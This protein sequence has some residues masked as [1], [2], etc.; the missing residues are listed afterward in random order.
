MISDNEKY[1]HFINH[2][3][4]AVLTT[5]RQSGNPVSSV[6][7]YAIDGNQLVI[8][9]PGMTFKRKTLEHD[10]RVNLTIISNEE[11]F[12]FVAIEGEATI[13]TNDI[14]A[15][16]KSVFANISGSGYEEPENLAEWLKIQKRVI[17][18]IDA[19]RIT[20]VIR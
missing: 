5:L 4:W 13:Q 2:H 10:P 3:R 18:R 6:V 19:K 9:T 14:I 15:P 16:T 11:P 8:S 1:E 17:I 12:N 7:A 20:G